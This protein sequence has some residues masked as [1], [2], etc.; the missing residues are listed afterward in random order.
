MKCP[1]QMNRLLTKAMSH[2]DN[3]PHS[4]LLGPVIFIFPLPQIPCFIVFATLL[5]VVELVS[6]AGR[7]LDTPS[8]ENQY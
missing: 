5:F 3:N 7:L 4:A 1:L 6:T 2:A 8:M